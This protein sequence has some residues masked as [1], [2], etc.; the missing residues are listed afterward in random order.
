MGSTFARLKSPAPLK[1]IREEIL[2]NFRKLA[3][4]AA[5]KDE[6]LPPNRAVPILRVSPLRANLKKALRIQVVSNSI[7]ILNS[8]LITQHPSS[9]L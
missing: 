7:F 5:G 4:M 2:K 3:E 9:S 8:S 1:P 6:A